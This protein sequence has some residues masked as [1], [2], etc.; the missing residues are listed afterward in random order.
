MKLG[1]NLPLV[2]VLITSFNRDQY[3]AE[4]IESVLS[5]TYPNFEV[6]IAD[7][8]ST[9]NTLAIASSFA[10]KDS[11]VTVFPNSQNLGQWPNRNRAASL[12]KGK[13]IKYVDS[14]DKIFPWSLQYCVDMMEKYPGAGMGII[15]LKDAIEDEYLQPIDTIQKNFFHSTILN[16]GPVGTILRNDSFTKVGLY[17]T[18]YGVPSDM[19]FNIKMASNFPV[20][21]LKEDFFFYRMHETQELNN[22]YS[23]LMHNFR[24]LRDALNLPQ[25]LLNASQKKYLLRRQCY[26]HVRS[27]LVY[28]KDTRALK[29]TWDIVQLSG[30]TVS[31]YLRG[32]IDVVVVKLKLKKDFN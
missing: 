9:D 1:M 15:Y 19:Y 26:W 3:I 23:Y 17:D 5:S 4:T 25:V 11:R 31:G 28:F 7:D 22:N 12:A 8:S 24:Y 20:V 32:V 14:D 21:L 2:S 30:V 6:I 10:E 16:V 27:L 29:K 13:Y 18:E